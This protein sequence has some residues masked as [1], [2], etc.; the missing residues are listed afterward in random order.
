MR[1]VFEAANAVEA[2]MVRDL[3]KQEGI[4]AHIHGE[5]LQGAMGELPAAGLVRL[6]VDEADYPRG[7]AVIEQWE[8]AQPLDA[9]LRPVPA[10][11]RLLIGIGI[12]LVGGA[13]LSWTFFHSAVSAGGIDNNGD[14]TPDERWFYTAA[15]TP[16][17]SETD[18]NFDGRVDVVTRFDRNGLPESAETDD[19]FDGVFE[20]RF[21]YRR[22]N[23]DTSEMDTDGDGFFDLRTRFEHGV[24]QATEY[25]DPATGRPLRIEYFRTG[26]LLR[27]EVDTDHDGELDTEQEYGPLAELRNVRRLPPPAR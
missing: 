16:L 18:R 11:S 14:G 1:T 19:N 21:T 9:P 5:H 24:M 27:A 4:V 6:V 10:R 13:V 12:G 15:G 25:L 7:R 17:R 3:L 2:H 20:G 26:K 8:A 22:G 23:V